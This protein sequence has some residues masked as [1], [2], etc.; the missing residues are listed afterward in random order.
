MKPFFVVSAAVAAA[1]AAAAAAFACSSS[2]AFFNRIFSS[3]SSTMGKKISIDD[4]AMY[5]VNEELIT[6]VISAV[7]DAKYFGPNMSVVKRFVASRENSLSK[8][9]FA[10]FSASS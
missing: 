8:T 6:C 4:I 3:C 5:V 10:I 2:S 9:F 7:T 1:A